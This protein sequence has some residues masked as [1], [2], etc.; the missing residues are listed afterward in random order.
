M[1]ERDV[2][3]LI[4]RVTEPFTGSSVSFTGARRRFTR[5]FAGSSVSFTGSRWRFKGS[6]VSFAGSF[7]GS[8]YRL[9]DHGSGLQDHGCHLRQKEETQS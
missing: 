2:V 8:S 7:T 5:S 6:S 9:R 4:Y 3:K 1:R